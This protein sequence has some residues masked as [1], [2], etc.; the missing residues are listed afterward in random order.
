VRILIDESLPRG[1]KRLLEGLDVLTVPEQGWQSMKNGE[2]LRR[3]SGAFDVFLTADQ[4]LE[5]QQNISAL[6]F[7]VVVLVAASNRVEAY[8]PLATKIREAVAA[9][10]PGT[11]TRVA[12]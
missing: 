6:P 12:A 4:N 11:V 9:A 5:H 2:L 10:R 7:A 8:A 3:A 1:L